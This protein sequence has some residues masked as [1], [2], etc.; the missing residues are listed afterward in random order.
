MLKTRIYCEVDMSICQKVKNTKIIINIHFRLPFMHFIYWGLLTT[1]HKLWHSSITANILWTKNV[2]SYLF[3]KPFKSILYVHT[4]SWTELLDWQRI[5]YLRWCYDQYTMC[6]LLS[7]SEWTFQL[8][9][10]WAA[11]SWT[12]H[13][14]V[15]G[16]AACVNGRCRLSCTECSS[17]RT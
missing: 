9:S 16:P 8:C 2:L 11:S 13:R 15:S 1:V 3:Q 17:I 14:L 12:V 6:V 10:Y 7:Q 4:M 5:T